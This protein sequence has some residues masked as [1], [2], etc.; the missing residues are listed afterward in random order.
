[1]RASLFGWRSLILAAVLAVLAGAGVWLGVAGN[2]ASGPSPNSAGPVSP[3]A[4]AN[5]TPKLD[6]QALPSNVRAPRPASCGGPSLVGANGAWL[7]DWLDDPSQPSLIAEQASRLRLLD[8][9]WLGLGITP[10]SIVQQPDNPG[11]ST[12]ETVLDEAAAANPCGWRFITISDEQTPMSVMAQILVDPAARWRNVTAL[13]AV[14]ASY[15]LADGLSLDYEYALPSTQ[16]DL[17]LY[18][19]VAHWHGLTAREEIGQITADYTEFVR[20]LALAMHRQHAALRVAVRVRTTDEVN[21]QDQSDL[22]PFLYDYG[23]LAKYADQ[24]VLMAVDFHWTTS[25]PGPIVTLADL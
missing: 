7:P 8:F 4:S 21:Y 5:G 25:D 15:P 14:M 3:P 11:G 22:L 20:E 23:A 19:S 2:R 17:D 6:L 16:Q 1:M 24:I 13:A 12:L 10:D 9:F 18:S